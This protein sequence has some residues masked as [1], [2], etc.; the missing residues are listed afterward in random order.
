MRIFLVSALCEGRREQTRNREESQ[1]SHGD[2]ALLFTS[3]LATV[4][5]IDE[6]SG[7]IAPKALY[8]TAN[9]LVKK[10]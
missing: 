1:D 8:R 4:C 10:I 5:P 9:Y 7:K 3:Y 6:M 2:S